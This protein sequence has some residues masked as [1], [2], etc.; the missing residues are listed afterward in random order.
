MQYNDESYV[1]EEGNNDDGKNHNNNK[2]IVINRDN[3]I[4]RTDDDI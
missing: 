1:L 4:V 2:H 3:P